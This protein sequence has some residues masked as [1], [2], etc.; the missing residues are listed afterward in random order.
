MSMRRY[1]GGRQVRVCLF[2]LPRKSL[3]RFIFDGWNE[4]GYIL[5]GSSMIFSD[6]QSLDAKFND[7]I[8]LMEGKLPMCDMVLMHKLDTLVRV[9]HTTDPGQRT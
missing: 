1:R 9:S 6:V 3:L 2:A 7:H 5:D 8:R 4:F